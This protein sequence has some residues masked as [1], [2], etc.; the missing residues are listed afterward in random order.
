MIGKSKSG[1]VGLGLAM[2]L[3]LLVSGFT[4]AQDVKYNFMPGTNFSK[5]HTYKWVSIPE[6]V[7]S[8]QIVDQEIR[9]AIDAQLNKKGLTKTDTDTADLDVGYQCSVDQ[10]R[11][12]NGFGMRGIG[13]AWGASRVPRFRMGRWRWIFTTPRISSWCGAVR[14]RRL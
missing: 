5:Y 11:Q 1:V 12:W 9:Q 14:Q 2:A 6:N 4:L 10:E 8:S 7:H 13:V 3:T